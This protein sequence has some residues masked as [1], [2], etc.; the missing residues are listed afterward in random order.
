MACRDWAVKA[1]EVD[2]GHVS[3][4]SLRWTFCPNASSTVASLTLLISRVRFPSKGSHTIACPSLSLT[5]TYLYS[6]MPLLV[7]A[8]LLP[9]CYVILSIALADQSGK[10]CA[11]VVSVSPLEGT[12]SPS[13]LL[14]PV[15]LTVWP[16]SV[17]SHLMRKLTRTL[18]PIL[19]S[20]LA[21][22]I[23]L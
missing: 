5:M 15:T 20:W 6:M 17:L 8:D 23:N 19:G 22:M 1:R 4:F 12:Q 16:G 14:G 3:I 18:S 11:F 2:V 10:S 21:S 9:P 13:A 7:R